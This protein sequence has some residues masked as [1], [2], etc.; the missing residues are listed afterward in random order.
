[1]NIGDLVV[2]MRRLQDIGY[3]T[4]ESN[5]LYGQLTGMAI[6]VVNVPMA[7]A[8]SMALAMV[9]AVAAASAAKDEKALAGNIKLGMRTASEETLATF[10][11]GLHG[12]ITGAPTKGFSSAYSAEEQQRLAKEL[13]ASKLAALRAGTTIEENRHEGRTDTRPSWLEHRRDGS[14]GYSEEML[15]AFNSDKEKRE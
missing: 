12:E 2:V 6:P 7:L 5:A 10:K 11:A 1:M 8:L 4:A 15:D 9:P 14:W 13:A 3:T